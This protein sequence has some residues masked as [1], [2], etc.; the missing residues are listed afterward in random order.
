MKRQSGLRI[1]RRFYHGNTCQPC[2]DVSAMSG[3]TL[4]DR[5]K[6]TM[7]RLEQITRAEYDVRIQWEWE[8]DDSGI[9][10][11]KPKFLAHPMVEQDPLNI[12]DTLC[13]IGPR[14]CA[15]ITRCART[16]PSNMLTSLA[17]THIFESISISR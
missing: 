12:R 5:Y 17:Y 13:G 15:S 3:E 6:R 9:V 7:T 8:F 2:R 1:L 10:K 11:Q 14:P 4:A 16:R